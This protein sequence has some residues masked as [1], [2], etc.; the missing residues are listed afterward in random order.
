MK[1]SS[2]VPLVSHVANCRRRRP[3]K[4]EI[5]VLTKLGEDSTLGQETI[6]RMNSLITE[7]TR[8]IIGLGQ[9]TK[10]EKQRERRRVDLCAGAN[11]G[12]DDSGSVQ[13]TEARRWRSDSDGLVGGG[14]V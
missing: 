8:V 3:Y 4:R 10:E 7:T 12:I 11:G 6:P 13:V 5:T 1:L 9:L 14:D 2:T